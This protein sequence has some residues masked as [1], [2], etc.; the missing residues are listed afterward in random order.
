MT[1]ERTVPDSEISRAID[2]VLAAEKDVG[3]TI[4]AATEAAE[5]IRREATESAH[6]ILATANRRIGAIHRKIAT[7]IQAE[8]TLLHGSADAADDQ[9]PPIDL[10]P[11]QLDRLAAAAAEW[12]TTDADD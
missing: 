4:E 6:R 2:E 5:D 10:D 11:G 1:D 12:L 9:E 7:D 8:I 3:R